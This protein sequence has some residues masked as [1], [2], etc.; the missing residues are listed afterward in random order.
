MKANP[1]IDELLCSF[2]DG[3]LPLRQ[4]TEIQRLMARDPDVARRLRQLQNTK[5]LVGALP[6]AEAPVEMLDQIK[7]TLERRS[8]LDERPAAVRATAGRRHLLVRKLVAA[9]AMIALLGVLGLVVYQIVAPVPP[10]GSPVALGGGGGATTVP[11]STGRVIPTDGGVTGR[12]EIRTAALVQTEASI[13]QAVEDYGLS[14]V[15]EPE[16]GSRSKVYRL[17]GSRENMRRLVAS[18]GGLWK[19]IEAATLHVGR[20]GEFTDPVAVADVTA[21][22]TIAILDQDTTEA[23]LLMA[24]RCAVENSMPGREIVKAINQ[25]LESVLAMAETSRPRLTKTQDGT[26]ELTASKDDGQ[27]SLTIVLLGA[28]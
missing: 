20:P 24:R 3:E 26:D 13:Q 2:I 11:A 8:L 1:N 18:L 22:Q 17:S 27:A 21:E 12:L 15:L 6:R 7:F 14:A 9:A 5:T 25:D 28:R 10:A 16:A 23:S 4:Q 19:K